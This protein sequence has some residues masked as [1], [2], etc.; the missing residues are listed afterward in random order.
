MSRFKTYILFVR[1]NKDLR[2]DVGKLGRCFF[3]KGEYIYAGAA[4]NSNRKRIERHFS[5][6][7]IKFWHIDYLLSSKNVEILKVFTSYRTSECEI[8]C[9]L[10]QY[11]PPV[12][13]FGSSDCKCRSHLYNIR[14][15]LDGLS[16]LLNNR[17]FSP[18][19]GLKIID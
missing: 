7:K 17:G 3:K 19:S 9:C 6:N 11:F 13:N 2:I 12:T 8:A 15:D 5:K 16:R 18:L 10:N 4:K 14:G 1:I